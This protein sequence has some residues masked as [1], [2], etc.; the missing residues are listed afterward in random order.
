MSDTPIDEGTNG[1]DINISDI[2][3]RLTQSP[4]PENAQN[5][6]PQESGDI[7]SSLLSNPELMAKIPQIISLL[8]PMLSGFFSGQKEEKRDSDAQKVS[9]LA[10]TPPSSSA[11]L[12]IPKS[13]SH[14]DSRAAL[15]CAIKPYLC[16]DRQA[17]VDYIIK[18]S[19]LGEI[20][21]TL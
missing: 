21:K 9:S 1:S 16:A 3:S 5:S 19:R 6:K 20:L 4:A 8:S 17:A 2:I 7:L 10:S 11:H 14:T 15:L 13:T 18:L 12:P